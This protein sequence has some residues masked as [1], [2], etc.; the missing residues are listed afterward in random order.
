V[1]DVRPYLAGSCVV[2]VP[3]RIDGGTPLKVEGLAMGRPMVTT[4]L[5]PDP[6]PPSAP[7]AAI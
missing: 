6:A 5:A 4:T 3:I 1:P 2:V 7:R